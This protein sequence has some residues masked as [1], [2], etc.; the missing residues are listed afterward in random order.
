M[1][2]NY[3]VETAYDRHEVKEFLERFQLQY[4]TNSEVTV[5]IRQNGTVVATGSLR[6]NVLQCFAEFG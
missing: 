4:D 3:A 2:H 5:V 6:D 1:W